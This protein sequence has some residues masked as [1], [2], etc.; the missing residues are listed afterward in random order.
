MTPKPLDA[1]LTTAARG[2][3]ILDAA[4]KVANWP[5]AIAAL[6]AEYDVSAARASKAVASAAKRLRHKQLAEDGGKDYHTFRIRL[7]RPQHERAVMLAN[8]E[9]G[10][11][12]SELFRQRTLG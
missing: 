2:I 12:V 9:T 11:N 3:V 6:V 5:A 8:Q 7:S 4:G 10:G 1:E